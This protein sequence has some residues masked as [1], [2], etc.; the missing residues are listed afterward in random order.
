MFKILCYD[1]LLLFWKMLDSFIPFFFFN[2]VNLHKN[3]G[4]VSNHPWPIRLWDRAGQSFVI[5][6]EPVL[7]RFPYIATCI[8]QDR[9][10]L[11]LMSIP[12]HPRTNATPSKFAQFGSLKPV[13][14]KKKNEWLNNGILRISKWHLWVVRKTW[15]G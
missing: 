8:R 3:I 7:V 9:S 15:L 4:L 14:K 1:F 11:R 6:Y 13:K 10:V 12:L 5:P 2:I